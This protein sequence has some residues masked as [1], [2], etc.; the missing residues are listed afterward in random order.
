MG[1]RPEQ[2]SMA[3]KE[4]DSV[5]RAMLAGDQVLLLRKGGIHERHGRFDPEHQQFLLFPTFL[6]QAADRVQ[7]AHRHL[8]PASRDAEP[9]HLTL[10]GWV[11]VSE[12]L[13]VPSRQAT[14][15]LKPH[16]IYEDDQLLMRWDYKP[17]RPLYVMLLRVYRLDSPPTIENLKRYAGCRSWVPLVEPVATA[18]AAPALNEAEFAQRCSAVRATLSGGQ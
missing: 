9:D 7:P 10:P 15:A 12:V 13:V 16:T 18:D 17:E 6:H 5:C 14:L 11:Q 1:D 4:W 3:M 2:L 8:V